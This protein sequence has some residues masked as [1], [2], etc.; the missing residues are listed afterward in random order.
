MFH[1]NVPN[2]KAASFFPQLDKSFSA[3]LAVHFD[4][5]KDGYT[6][7][8]DGSSMWAGPHTTDGSNNVF[9]ALFAMADRC[10]HAKFKGWTLKPKAT[11][12]NKR[13]QLIIAKTAE[14]VRFVC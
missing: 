12:K 11:S 10:G 3:N 9:D 6:F 14:A 7:R 4:Q 5:N 2:F 1:T 13:F 8:L